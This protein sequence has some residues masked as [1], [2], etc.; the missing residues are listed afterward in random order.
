MEFSLKSVI[1]DFMNTALSFAICP[2]VCFVYFYFCL[3]FVCNYF[4]HFCT[5]YMAIYI[6]GQLISD[7]G[8]FLI[9]CFSCVL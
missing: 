1:G 4:I 3:C 9:V 5:C 7:V 6:N 2:F 8:L